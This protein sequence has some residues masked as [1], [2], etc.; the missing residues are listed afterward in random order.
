MTNQTLESLQ[1]TFV[2]GFKGI[3]RTSE[4][5]KKIFSST[6]GVFAIIISLV[7]PFLCIK[8]GVDIYSFIIEIKGLMINFLPNILGFTI[9]GYTLVI[10]FVQSNMMD[11]ITEPAKDSEFSL[12]QK[13]S[14][15]FAVNILVQAI[16]LLIAF[17]YNIFIYIDKN[18]DKNIHIDLGCFTNVINYAGLTFLLFCFVV[19]SMVTVQIILNIF[20]FSQLHHFMIVKEKIDKKD[21]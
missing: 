15:T 14:G 1:E 2:L 20:E 9:A 11:K 12:Y 18:K 17:T 4:I 16:A 5:G 13:M 3:R 7:L 6:I 21:Q 8:I 19:S 10:G